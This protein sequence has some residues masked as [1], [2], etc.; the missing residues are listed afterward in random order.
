[1]P[2]A[3]V[4]AALNIVCI[5]HA[6]KTGRFNPWG[7]VVLFLPGVGAVAYI[8]VEL[9]PEW[10]GSAEGRRARQRVSRTLNPEQRYRELADDLAISDT[11]ANRAALAEECLALGKFDEARLHF[12]TVLVQPL[13]EDPIY[14]AGRA[15]AEF[16]LGQMLQVVATLD[17]L[18]QRWPDYQSADAHLLYARA[19]EGTDRSAEALEEYAALIRYF[20]G[21]E[22][23]VRYG[24]LLDR[25]GRSD[26]AKMVFTDVVTQLRRAP[27]YAR[28]AQAEWNAIAE[29]Q[30]RGR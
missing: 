6:A 27:K 23:R 3:L 2:I 15:R 8:A 10:F 18:R 26:Q 24:L 7:Y 5:I 16:G 29:R 11:I 13:G 12:D 4:L 1:M 30:L 25:M 28:N 21:A 9:I 17:E 19:L 14:F 20:P 22:A